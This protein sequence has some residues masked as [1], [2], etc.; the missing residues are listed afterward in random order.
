MGGDIESMV[1]STYGCGQFTLCILLAWNI[2]D[3]G[4]RCRKIVH[5]T[6]HTKGHVH[7]PIFGWRFAS[8]ISQIIHSA[9][10]AE[11]RIGSEGCVQSCFMIPVR[12][13]RLKRKVD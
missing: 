6:P 13:K 4:Y 10:L 9:R 11:D 7:V 3:R 2:G 12:L 1:A 8:D 5:D